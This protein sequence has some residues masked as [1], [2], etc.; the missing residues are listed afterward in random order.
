MVGD[1]FAKGTLTGCF[2]VVLFS[3][4]ANQKEGGFFN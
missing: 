1:G 3:P 4:H 2:F